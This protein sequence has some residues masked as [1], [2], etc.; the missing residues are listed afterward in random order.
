MH[1][2]SMETTNGH[3]YCVFSLVCEAQVEASDQSEE[4]TG[5]GRRGVRGL[6]REQVQ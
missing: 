5:A 1:F 2:V 4:A 6:A 3:I